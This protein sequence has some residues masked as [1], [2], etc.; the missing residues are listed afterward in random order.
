MNFFP[1][2]RS[3]WISR[4]RLSR[5]FADVCRRS[6]CA[7]I[8][9]SLFVT[10]HHIQQFFTVFAVK[11]A[12]RQIRECGYFLVYCSFDESK[13]SG[14]LSNPVL[15]SSPSKGIVPSEDVVSI[16]FP[17]SG[18]GPSKTFSNLREF[19]NTALTDPL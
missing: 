7:Q 4:S 11:I 8:A 3:L 9:L 13:E 17:S 6:Q 19:C 15:S 2:I 5:L 1:I 16:T 10:Y 12:V 18:T 14:G